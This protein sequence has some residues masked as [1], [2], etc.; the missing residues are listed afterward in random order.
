MLRGGSDPNLHDRG[1]DTYLCS[2]RGTRNTITFRPRT[3]PTNAKETDTLKYVYFLCIYTAPPFH[4]LPDN[5]SQQR[6]SKPTLLTESE[7]QMAPNKKNGNKRRG[8]FSPESEPNRIFTIYGTQYETY[9]TPN[10]TANQIHHH[11]NPKTGRPREIPAPRLPHAGKATI[12]SAGSTISSKR[13]LSI[14][15]TESETENLGRPF[16]APP[17]QINWRQVAAPVGAI[18][19]PQFL[20]NCDYAH[21]PSYTG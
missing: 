12:S 1:I 19:Q 17:R 16:S 20:T 15:A 11:K 5:S 4:L 8:I 6:D 13:R 14:H 3:A 7:G 2:S 21:L 10:V 9:F 18:L